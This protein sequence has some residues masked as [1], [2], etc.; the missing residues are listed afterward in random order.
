MNRARPYIGA[1]SKKKDQYYQLIRGQITQTSINSISALAIPLPKPQQ[2]LAKG[3]AW[4]YEMLW[5]DFYFDNLAFAAANAAWGASMTTTSAAGVQA[6]TALETMYTDNNAFANAFVFEELS[7]ATGTNVIKKPD[8][9]PLEDA[10]GN[11]F[12]V[13]TDSITMAFGT[14]GLAATVGCDMRLA[15]RITQVDLD[16]FIGIL[17]QQQRFTS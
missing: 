13:A 12:L 10:R 7:S 11:G 8:R 2:S 6:F 3:K 15:Y 16:E 4:V 9:Y 17:A 5:G 1:M 14:T